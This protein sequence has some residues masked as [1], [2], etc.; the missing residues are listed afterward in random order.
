MEGTILRGLERISYEK[1]RVGT[2]QPRKV[3]AHRGFISVDKYLKEE[4]KEDGARFFLVVS[5]ARKR[6]NGH[7]L[8]NRRFHL[9]FGEH[10]TVLVTTQAKTAHSGCGV[11][12]LGDL[13]NLPGCGLGQ[14]CLGSL[15]LED[16][17]WIR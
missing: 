11:S 16:E 1:L 8:E 2:V 10:C 9:N 4:C 7:K 6:D 12:I 17:S 14:Q 5:T 3:E 13:Q 15:S